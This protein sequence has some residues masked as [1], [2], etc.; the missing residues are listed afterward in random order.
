MAVIHVIENDFEEKV[1]KNSKPVVVDFS[2]DWC[3]PCKMIAP[4]FEELSGEMQEVVF[5]KADVDDCR[6]A[7]AMYN[8]MSV[9]TL[10]LFKAGEIKNQT[11]GA[12][13]KPKLKQ[14]IE[15]SIK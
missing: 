5:V 8:V 6:A 9:P 3:M 12:M 2:A 4:L 1:L 10:I 15:E 13:Q 11:S 14:W 7:A